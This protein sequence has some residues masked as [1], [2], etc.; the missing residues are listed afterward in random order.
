MI[1]LPTAERFSARLLL[2]PIQYLERN[3]RFRLRSFCLSRLRVREG[4]NL[5]RFSS[6]LIYPEAIEDF[7]IAETAVF[8][9]LKISLISPYVLGRADLMR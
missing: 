6:V 2:R 4:L 1:P 8:T 5:D 9:V 3:L 7:P